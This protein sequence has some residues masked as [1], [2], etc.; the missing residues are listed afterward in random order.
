MTDRPLLLLDVDGVL[1]P[2]LMRKLPPGYRWHEIGIFDLVLATWHGPAI[3]ELCEESQLELVWAT[4][5]EEKANLEI[6]PRVGLPTDLPWITFA[7]SGYDEFAET[8]KLAPVQRFVG[9]RPCVW[10][11][12]DLWS[13][14]WVWAV[15]RREAGIP[16]L[17]VQPQPDRGLVRAH[18][19]EITRWAAGIG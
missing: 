7:D 14:A 12:D 9:E 18:L 11:D 10:I 4:T 6:S 19:Q 15:R 1:N 17:L 8:R 5:W 13:D 3:L 16:T 2:W